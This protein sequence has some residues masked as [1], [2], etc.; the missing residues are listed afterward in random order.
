MT[1]SSLSPYFS[2]FL[3]CI[4]S[5]SVSCLNAPV[6]KWWPSSAF[7]GMSHIFVAFL[8]LPFP[9]KWQFYVAADRYSKSL[10]YIWNNSQGLCCVSLHSFM[11]NV[12]PLLSTLILTSTRSFWFS[13]QNNILLCMKYSFR[14][15]NLVSS[16]TYSQNL[17]ISQA[18]CTESY[19]NPVSPVCKIW[20]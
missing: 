18:N 15:V 7:S 19:R 1:K 4:L 10:A 16:S 5:F 3:P 14:S 2:S 11:L 6:S 17:P 13:Y 9:S 8:H 12:R 20:S